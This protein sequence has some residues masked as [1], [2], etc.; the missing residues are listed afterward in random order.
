MLPLAWRVARVDPVFGVDSSG[1]VA[2]V[3]EAAALWEEAVGRPMFRHDDR[4]GFPVRFLQRDAEGRG[5]DEAAA[6]FRRAEEEYGAAAD[7]LGRRLGELQQRLGDEEVRRLAHLDRLAG[8]EDEVDR[9]NREVEGWRERGGAPE[10]VAATLQEREAGLLTERTLLADE[11]AAL[12]ALRDTLAADE[13]SLRADVE[14]HRLR[15]EELQASLP[16]VREEAGFYREAIR[17][18]ADGTPVVGREIRVHRPGD[19]RDLVRILAHELGHA[20][21]LPHLEVP[22]ALMAAEYNRMEDRGAV[23][24]GPAD[25]ERFRRLCPGG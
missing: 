9:H 10:G 20:L 16:P 12:E 19:R 3:S 17:A 4:E 8:F 5:A 6:A 24:V 15:G 18:G 14:A 22:G 1:A 13:A 25:V 2:L 21:G 23:V 11:R 7:L